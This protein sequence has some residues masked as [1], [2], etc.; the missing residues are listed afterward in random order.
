MIGRIYKIIDC[1]SNLCYV[2]ST[3]SE[4]KQRWQRHKKDYKRWVSGISSE[5]SIYPFFQKFGIGRFKIILIKEYQVADKTHLE[6]YEQLW[7]NK[8]ECVN[9]NNPVSIKTLY[10]KQYRSEHR[11]MA[12]AYANEYRS[13]NKELLRE[14]RH[15]KFSCECGGKYTRGDKSRHF[16]TKK[17]TLHFNV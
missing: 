15:E 12:N 11:E 17:H 4:L 3:G 9:K 8:L 1:Q 2:G 10:Y 6:A 13:K 5:I 16:K 7:I 14:K